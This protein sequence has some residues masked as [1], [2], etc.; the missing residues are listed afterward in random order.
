MIEHLRTR[1]NKSNGEQQPPFISSPNNGPACL[2][3]IATNRQNSCLD[4]AVDD[5]GQAQVVAVAAEEP[6]VV[7][8]FP[9]RLK[10][11]ELSAAAA[12]AAAVST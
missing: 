9:F 11:K 7:L 6:A 1:Q 10:A 2:V 4:F 5:E 8:F 3:R 12:A